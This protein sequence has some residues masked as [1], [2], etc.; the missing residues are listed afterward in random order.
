[1]ETRP[2]HGTN[3]GLEEAVVERCRGGH[4][5]A[6]VVRRPDASERYWVTIQY[7]RAEA[8]PA[9]GRAARILNP[10]AVPLKGN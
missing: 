10:Q 4:A 3:H 7:R 6:R 8:D 5:H 9:R 2:T 1:M